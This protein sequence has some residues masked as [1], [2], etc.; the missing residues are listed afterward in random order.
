MTIQKH[1]IIY[2]D[3]RNKEVVRKIRKGVHAAITLIRRFNFLTE[4]EI[5]TIILE[6]L[7]KRRF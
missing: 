3:G 4:E 1:H 7:L 6:C 5:N 2:G